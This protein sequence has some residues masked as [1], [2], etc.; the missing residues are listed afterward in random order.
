MALSIIPYTI[1]RAII[2]MRTGIIQKKGLGGT[3]E[4]EFKRRKAAKKEEAS[5]V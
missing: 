5:A 3:T 2:I 1:Q 4:N